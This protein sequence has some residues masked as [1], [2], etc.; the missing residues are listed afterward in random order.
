M[1]KNEAVCRICRQ[2]LRNTQNKKLTLVNEALSMSAT[3]YW[4]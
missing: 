3:I 1:F 4:T 2:V